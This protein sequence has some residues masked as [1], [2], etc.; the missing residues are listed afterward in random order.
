[1][2]VRRWTTALAAAAGVVGAG[3]AS[4]QEAAV[5]FVPY[6]GWGVA[7]L[8]LAVS[9]MG[10]AASRPVRPLLAPW[11]TI[12]LLLLWVTLAATLAA[13][14]EVV[15][16]LTGWPVAAGAAGM[17][18]LAAVVPGRAGA[19]RI[20]GVTV[21]FLAAAILLVGGAAASRPWPGA[22]DGAGPNGRWTALPGIAAAGLDGGL[23][24]REV[25]APRKNGAPR[26]GREAGKGSSEPL[27]ALLAALLYA[28]YSSALLA[29]G[30]AGGGRRRDAWSAAALVGILLAV[31][32]GAL[33]RSP[34]AERAALPM[35]AVAGSWGS[36]PALAYAWL[37]GVAAANSALA[38]TRALGSGLAALPGGPPAARLAVALLAWAASSLGLAELVGRVYPL[39]GWAWLPALLSRGRPCAPAERRI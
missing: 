12:W 17:G 20:Q 29:G 22:G 6:G 9:L 10:W 8:V 2:R 30:V 37:L 33:L 1:M 32:S 3:F 25:L 38:T 31:M 19:R 34:A 21:L 13:G 18:A 35:L 36:G 11:H 26:G 5:F 15:H 23:G 28:S 24:R 16:Q 4:G 39:L 14:G 27:G 7:G